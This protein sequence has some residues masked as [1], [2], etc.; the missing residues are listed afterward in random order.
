MG[1]TDETLCCWEQ[2]GSS[3]F[4]STIEPFN[5]IPTKNHSYKLKNPA[6]PYLFA[7]RLV[8]L[9]ELINFYPYS[10]TILDH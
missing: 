8:F 4:S 1:K 5:L 6:F 9:L 3:K 7:K 2:I 10:Y